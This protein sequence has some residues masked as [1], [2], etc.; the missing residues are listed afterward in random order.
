LALSGH[1]LVRCTCLLLTR[2]RRDLRDAGFRTGAME[3]QQVDK[4]F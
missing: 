3:L 4:T 2:S 1:G